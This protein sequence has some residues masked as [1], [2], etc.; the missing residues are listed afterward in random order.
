[1]GENILV[2]PIL[3]QGK[4]FRGVYLPKG[5]WYDYFTGEKIKGGRVVLKDAPID[6]CP[7]YIKEGS[8]IPTF[9]EMSYVGQNGFDELVLEVYRGNGTYVHY[10][11]DKETF[12][13]KEGEYN[14][15]KIEQ[16]VE[17]GKIII[18]FNIQH[19]GYN[20]GYKKIKVKLKNSL[21][22]SVYADGKEIEFTQEGNDTVVEMNVEDKQ[23][24]FSI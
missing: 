13:Y 7:I 18:N 15:Y 2:A 10:E 14:L 21:V 17:D 8:I 12:N 6:I 11:D 5:S 24:I 20:D 16:V 4:T 1:M 3:E 9:N 19:K 23:I 22:K